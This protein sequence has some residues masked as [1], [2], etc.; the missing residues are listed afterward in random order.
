MRKDALFFK[1]KKRIIEL[2][3][4]LSRGEH[5]GITELYLGF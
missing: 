5:S 2:P 4:N 1:L 3:T